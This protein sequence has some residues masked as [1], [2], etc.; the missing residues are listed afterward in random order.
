MGAQSIQL[1]LLGRQKIICQPSAV[2]S[3]VT[4]ENTQYPFM[5]WLRFQRRKTTEMYDFV[6]LD[7]SPT[8]EDCAQV[9]QPDYNKQAKKECQVFARVL[10]EQFGNPPGTARLETKSFDHE[11]GPYYLLA[12]CFDPEDKLGSEYARNL[13]NNLPEFWPDWAKEELRK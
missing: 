9:G 10:T 5:E 3:I 11:F 2:L 1:L 4:Q 12:C 8:E 7:Q 13:E 6:T